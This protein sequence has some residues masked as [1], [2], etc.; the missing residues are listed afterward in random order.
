[1]AVTTVRTVLVNRRRPSCRIPRHHPGGH[2]EQAR[3]PP[4]RG[5]TMAWASP[6]VWLTPATG[7]TGPLESSTKRWA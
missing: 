6:P 7:M 2:A 3:C 1:M 5:P 4:A